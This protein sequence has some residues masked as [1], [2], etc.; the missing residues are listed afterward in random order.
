MKHMQKHLFPNT[1]EQQL[2]Y[3]RK[4]IQGN[5]T[6]LQLGILHVKDQVLMGTISLSS[7]DHLNRKCEIGGFIG[8]KKYQKFSYFIEANNIIIKHGFD[9]LNMNRIYGGTIIKEVASMYCR[10]LGF[11]E[12][13]ILRSDV[14]KNG[15]YYDAYLIGLLRED[16][17]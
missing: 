4:N 5:P 2:E 17:A 8:E 7:I 10:V 1:K 3:F 16:Y 14:Y 9:N 6:K 13:G 12:E 11:K 15:K